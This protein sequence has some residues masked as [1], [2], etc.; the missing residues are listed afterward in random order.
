MP[1]RKTERR[2][3]AGF[4]AAQLGQSKAATGNPKFQLV[5]FL[6]SP[7]ALRQ[8][9]VYVVFV[10][11]TTAIP[12][13]DT[14]VWAFANGGTT[15]LTTTTGIAEFTPQNVGPLTVSV[16]V[17][18]G[19]STLATISLGQQVI[20]LNEKLEL[21]ID[22]VDTN[23]ATAA[24]PETSRELIDGLRA[25]LD[26]LL[27]QKP[28][29]TYNKAVSSL[30]YAHGLETAG[31]RRRLLLER[32]AKVLNDGKHKDF[33][34]EAK[35]GFG[36]CKTRPQLAAMFLP[37]GGGSPYIPLTELPE[38]VKKRAKEEA[39][40]AKDF[41]ALSEDDKIDLFNL[42]RFP[43]SHFAAV[44][45][46]LDG[47]QAKYFSGQTVPDVLKTKK[48]GMPFLSQFEVGPVTGKIETGP[49]EDAWKLMGHPIWAIPVAPIAGTTAGTG[50]A[51]A[52]PVG[53]PEKVPTQTFIAADSPHDNKFL[54]QARVYHDSFGLNHDT[55][56]SFEKMVETLAGHS[57]AIARL[58]IVSHFYLDP[59]KAGSAI[60]I[61]FFEGHTNFDGTRFFHTDHWFFDY[62]KGDDEGL[63]AY[64][65]HQVL[66]DRKPDYV[67]GSVQEFNSPSS[68][69]TSPL[70]EVLFKVLKGKGSA[71]LTPF[72]FGN[73][74]PGGAPRRMFQQCGN[75]F[76]LEHGF[77]IRALGAHPTKPVQAMK[78]AVMTAAV[79]Q[80]EKEL[81][82]LAGKAPMTKPNIDAV[83]AAVRA[84]GMNDLPVPAG[85]SGF[86]QTLDFTI[87]GAFLEDHSTLRS[88]LSAVRDRLKNGV[89]DVRG[90]RIGDDPTYMKAVRAFFS[91]STGQPTVTAP[92]WFQ[93][94][95][96]VTNIELANETEI[97]ALFDTGVDFTAPTPDLSKNDV[98]R[99][100]SDW[101][102]AIGI[103]AQLSFWSTLFSD[104]KRFNFLHRGWI[105]QLPPIGLEAAQL[106][107][108]GSLTH[109]DLFG[110]L[111]DIFFIPATTQPEANDLATFTFGTQVVD[112]KTEQEAVNSLPTNPSQAVLQGHLTTIQSLASAVSQTLNTAPSPLTEQYLKDSI[113]LVGKKL[114]TLAKLDPLVDA[115]KAKSQDVHFGIR[116]MIGI[117]LP[118]IAQDSAKEEVFIAAFLRSLKVP[119]LRSLMSMQWENPPA[120]M[121]SAIAAITPGTSPSDTSGTPTNDYAKAL[122][123]ARL[124]KEEID[125]KNAA[126]NPENEFANQIVSEPP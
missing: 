68:S 109:A 113:D 47:L 110:R 102:G 56:T 63:L 122:Q 112:L 92:N 19:T 82:A 25:Y 80:A 89:I 12:N 21:L 3:P 45:T 41:D 74:L 67:S 7:V 31:F 123:V 100:F 53:R 76:A 118:L 46:I 75:I 72:G 42:L 5:S 23:V 126:I 108:L 65:V 26:L 48:T 64:F 105:S 28:D 29:P 69:K 4:T 96:M 95:T 114:V 10:T 124:D 1:V 98:R 116:Y 57:G 2:I 9:Q 35:T 91:K 33:L 40:I 61:P 14:Y 30:A 104:E 119:A 50:T 97:D 55:A 106:S 60:I 38:K 93:L 84:L 90:C 83:L 99:G 27:P 17:K 86:S 58:R 20:A 77:T 107:G 66:V 22:Q 11:D 6:S 87:S 16:T 49:G 121:K 111:K 32:L 117:G 34:K 115:L 39:A 101:A 43:K 13:V 8:T 79:A 88:N 103:N 52:G 24:H 120:F 54:P 37:K 70:Y 125:V 18:A 44:K 62:G 15:N 78:P 85:R 81:A 36:V 73:S 71:A 51:T 59:T 94:F